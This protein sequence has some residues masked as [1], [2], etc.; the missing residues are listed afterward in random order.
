[1]NNQPEH[2]EVSAPPRE[3]HL[4]RTL[5][6]AVAATVVVAGLFVI[7]A[8]R[9][10]GLPNSSAPLRV[11][12]L[13]TSISTPL[14]NLMALSPVPHTR[15]HAFSLTDQRG[16]AISLASFRG[17]AVVLEFMDPHCT[18]ICP[19]I[20]Q[21]LIDA[22]K[23][24]GSK[25]SR[26]VFLAVNVNRFHTSVADMRTFTNEHSLSSIQ[27]SLL[28]AIWADY[29]VT[30]VAPSPTADVVHSSL[31]FFINRKGQE[32][33]LANPTDLHT[34]SGT[35][36]LPAGSLSDWGKGIA[37]VVQAMIK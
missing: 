18:D 10:S 23:D 7:L 6:A 22:N 12:G 17:R 33:Y 36:Y 15:A 11:S 20:S 25:A 16:R 1:M 26:V 4:R 5:I 29:G 13:P 28:K 27:P 2:G 14:A 3:S 21:E 8:H 24:L 37:L 31:I 30:V 9:N 19:I 32:Q 34:A 35:S